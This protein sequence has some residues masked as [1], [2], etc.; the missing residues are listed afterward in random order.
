M[1]VRTALFAAVYFVLTVALAPISYGPFQFRLSEALVLLPLLFPVE[2]AAGLTAGCLL[3]NIFSPTGWYDVVFGSLS[4]LAACLVSVGIRWAFY[5]RDLKNSVFLPFLGGIPHILINM[6][7]L[8]LMWYMLGLEEVFWLNVG[9][10]ALTEAATVYAIGV[11][12]YFALLKLPFI[13]NE[14]NGH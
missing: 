9:M 1:L 14:L 4:T 6:I 3:A 7:V 12:L 8:P 2:G 11:P 5:K 13:K 10:I